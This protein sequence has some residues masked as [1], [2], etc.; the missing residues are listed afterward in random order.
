MLP[1]EDAIW[2]GEELTRRFGLPR[3]Q[4]AL[5]ATDA[6][7]FAIRLARADHG[8]AE[9]PRLQL[10]LPRH[11][12]RDVRDARRRRGRP[13]RR[14]PRP[15]GAARRDDARRRVE[16]RSRRSRRELAHGDVAL[17]AR[18]AGADEH[19]DRPARAR[20]STTRCARPRAG[21]DTLLVDRRDAHDLRRA[22]RVH[23][24]ARPRAG[25]AHDRQADRRRHPGGRLRLHARS[26]R[27]DRRG[28]A[29]RGRSDV[30]GDRRHARRERALARGDARHARRG[31]HR[32]GVRADDRRS[33]S[34]SRPASQARS[35]G[36]SCRGT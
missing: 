3:W 22:R 28:D 2:V 19:R 24:R 21:T 11:R 25:R 33:A 36:T 10:V 27:P 26:R 30:G 23:G 8:P 6:N 16:R 31:A 15:A 14:Q 32:R 12:R 18:R 9:D 20:A 13:A 1:S 29:A 7:R 5:T 34:G 17:R 35:S 4:F